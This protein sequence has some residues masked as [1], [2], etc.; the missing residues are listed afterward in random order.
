M[1]RR[2]VL[3]AILTI[4]LEVQLPSYLQCMVFETHIKRQLNPIN[5][6]SLVPL[7]TELKFQTGLNLYDSINSIVQNVDL[8][9]VR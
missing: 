4:S 1:G 2:R 9:C 6:L 7:D 5:R 8:S 3:L